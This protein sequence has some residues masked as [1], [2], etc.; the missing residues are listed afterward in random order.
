M[1]AHPTPHI[2]SFFVCMYSIIA[3]VSELGSS[4]TID[5]KNKV[6]NHKKNYKIK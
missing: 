4:Y 3:G 6:K 5:L 2:I 1:A